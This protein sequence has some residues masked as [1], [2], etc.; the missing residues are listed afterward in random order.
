MEAVNGHKGVTFIF[1]TGS[2]YYTEILDKAAEKGIEPDQNVRICSYINDMPTYLSA[3]DLIISRAGALSVAETTVCGK[4]AILIPSPNVTG[5]HQYFN[6]KSV[7]DKGGAILLEEK[8]LTSEGLIS[9]VMRLRNNPEVLEK[10]SRASAQCAP[11]DACEVIYAEIE[12][13]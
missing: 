7:A 9:E 8:D 12:K 3:S 6:A 13:E 10:M 5:N 1:G 11:L 2:Q 4:A